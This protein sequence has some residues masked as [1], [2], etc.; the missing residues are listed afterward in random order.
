MKDKIIYVLAA[1]VIVMG[2]AIAFLIVS[3]KSLKKQV[4]LYTNIVEIQKKQLAAKPQVTSKKETVYKPVV[5]PSGD[6]IMSPVSE[7]IT[8]VEVPQSMLDEIANLKAEN[9]KLKSELALAGQVR[10][11]GFQG[12]LN[13]DSVKTVGADYRMLKNFHIGG[14]IDMGEKTYPGI[15]FRIDF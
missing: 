11:W 5:S 8:I 12:E 9:A 2:I 10:K 1:V 3:N 15:Y 4:A 13:T 14:K 7:T 6:V